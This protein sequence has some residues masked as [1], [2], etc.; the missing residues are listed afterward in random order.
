MCFHSID[1]S[2]LGGHLPPE[3]EI[4]LK[5]IKQQMGIAAIL[6]TFLNQGEVNLLAHLFDRDA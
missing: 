2:R 5:V 1:P 6:E 4:P 3:L